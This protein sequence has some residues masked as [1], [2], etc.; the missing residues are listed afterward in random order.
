MDRRDFL[1]NR[2]SVYLIL[3][4]KKSGFVN[5]TIN[6]FPDSRLCLIVKIFVVLMLLKFVI[7]KRCERTT[8]VE[9]SVSLV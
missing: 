7:T 8:P 5:G 6:D 9:G 1:P 2:G 4:L 3:Y